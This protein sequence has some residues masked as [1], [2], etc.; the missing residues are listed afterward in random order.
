MPKAKEKKEVKNSGAMSAKDLS[1]E[2]RQELFQVAFNQFEAAMRDQFGLGLS[3]EIVYSPRAAVPRITLVDLLKKE[4]GQ[5]N[6]TT[7]KS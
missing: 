1:I 6:Q 7:P 2:K 3:A 5:A 4:N